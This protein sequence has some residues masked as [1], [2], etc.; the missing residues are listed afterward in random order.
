M[1]DLMRLNKFLSEAG[2]C[3]RREADRLISSGDITVNGAPTVVG[4][5]VSAGDEIC[6]QGQLVIREDKAVL[7]L[8]NKPRG[9]VCTAQKRE[10][11]NVIDY[12]NYPLRIYPVGRL[13]KDSQGLLLMT[14]QGDL[15]N[16]IMR[17]GNFHEKEYLVKVD[18]KITKEFL[19]Q[20]R[21][22]V[23]ILETVT[24]CCKVKRIDDYTFNIILTQ[25]LNRQIRR[26]CE[27]LG[28]EVKQLKRI[29]VMNFELGE[30]VVGK[31]RE[32]SA[33]EMA[34][35]GEALKGS[36]SLPWN[37]RDVNGQQT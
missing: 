14:N 27:Y 25:G 19:T 17:A 12:I 10:K 4:M 3:S 26:M 20:M 28:Y 35:L 24:R 30:L 5:Q 34:A 33:K 32:A 13:D 18:K 37:E 2:V 29:R 11:N 16:K 31:Y 22:G 8:F 15:V 21:S 6:Y 36:T 23:P 9:I 1:G 7:L